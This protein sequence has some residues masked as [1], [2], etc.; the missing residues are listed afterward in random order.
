MGFTKA[1]W[2]KI[3]HCVNSRAVSATTGQL[4]ENSP[5]ILPCDLI[6]SPLHHVG[7]LGPFMRL[8]KASATRRIKHLSASRRRFAP[9][10]EDSASCLGSKAPAL[11][12][13]VARCQG[14]G[15]HLL[16]PFS[17][18]PV[19]LCFFRSAVKK[20]T[21]EAAQAMTACENYK[22]LFVTVS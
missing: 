17:W 22:E 18:G 3:S 16:L 10:T 14:P 7:W 5:G 4:L 2:A 21:E 6:S 1:L 11:V 9:L 19:G 15:E 13:S 12:D 20:R 8:P